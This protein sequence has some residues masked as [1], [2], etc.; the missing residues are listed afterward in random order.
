MGCGPVGEAN[1]V[2]FDRERRL[3]EEENR[4]FRV[5]Q[6]QLARADAVMDDL[7]TLADLLTRS[8]MLLAGFYEHH[9]EWRRRG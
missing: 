2:L 8:A 4:A 7:R 5:E 9:G 1:A 6:E 3:R